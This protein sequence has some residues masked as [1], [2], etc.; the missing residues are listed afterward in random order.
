MVAVTA[1]TESNSWFE[2]EPGI[3]AAPDKEKNCDFA[4][5]Y[6][7]GPFNRGYNFSSSLHDCDVGTVPAPGERPRP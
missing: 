6:V 5:N 2:P 4:K 7:G 1:Q 3:R